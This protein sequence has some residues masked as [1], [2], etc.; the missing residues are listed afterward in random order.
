MHCLQCFY[1]ESDLDKHREDCLD[2]NGTQKIVMPTEGS[3]VYFKNYHKQLAAC[4]FC[5]LC[6]FRSYH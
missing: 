1:S 5:Y 4:A 2:L 6:R 3:E